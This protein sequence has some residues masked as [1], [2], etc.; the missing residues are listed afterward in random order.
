MSQQINLF[1]PGLVKV[2]DQL[3]LRNVGLIYVTI[4]TLLSLYQSHLESG[5]AEANAEYEKVHTELT[6][7]QKTLDQLSDTF[8]PPA[9]SQEDEKLLSKLQQSYKNQSNIIEIFKLTQSGEQAHV[10]DYLRGLAH[11][12]V[13]NVW[14]TGMKLEPFKKNVTLRGNSLS[15]DLVP[16]YMQ[17]LGKE[18][19]FSGQLF[20]G[21][22]LKE[23]DVPVSPS[24]AT[25]SAS[26]T[27]ANKRP[28]ATE[29][30]SKVAGNAHNKLIEF[31]MTGFDA[32]SEPRHETE[33]MGATTVDHA[34]NQGGA[35]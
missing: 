19:V 17:A 24:L 23:V 10:A 9:N 26:T 13:E 12:P 16:A 31:E 22:K 33:K 30:A 14:L 2:K 34:V 11:R 4:F 7:T 8:K 35:K 3:S 25:P 6:A 5:L 29:P 32:N 20:D 1:N 15:A 18:P 21:L 28:P 27:E